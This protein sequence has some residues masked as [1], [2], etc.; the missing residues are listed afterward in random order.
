VQTNEAYVGWIGLDVSGAPIA[1]G[2]GYILIRGVQVNRF[3]LY[4]VQKQ[5]KRA[6]EFHIPRSLGLCGASVVPVIFTVD[7]SGTDITE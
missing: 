4:Q 2:R 5:G 7:I 6:F 1:N 3:V